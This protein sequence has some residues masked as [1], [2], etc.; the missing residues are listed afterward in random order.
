[1]ASESNFLKEEGLK[2]M[3]VK[4]KDQTDRA[5]VKRKHI[6]SISGNKEDRLAWLE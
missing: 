3:K 1:M 2:H 6:P 5:K 4:E